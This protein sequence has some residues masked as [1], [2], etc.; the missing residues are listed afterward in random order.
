M[1]SSSEDDIVRLVAYVNIMIRKILGIRDCE[2]SKIANDVCYRFPRI[3]ALDGI[4]IG[5]V[6]RIEQNTV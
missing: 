5:N 1:D 3:R 6:A 2:T 4:M